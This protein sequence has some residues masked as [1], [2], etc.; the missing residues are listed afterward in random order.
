MIIALT[1][2]FHDNEPEIIHIDTDKLNPKNPVDNA[3]LKG[4][5]TKRNKTTIDA[6]DWED[7][8]AYKFQGHWAE[9][10]LTAKA[11]SKKPQGPIER[12]HIFHILFDC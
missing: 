7:D 12:A 9:P 11:Q 8:D 4:L 1:H 10:H 5:K 3:L 6:T 2:Q